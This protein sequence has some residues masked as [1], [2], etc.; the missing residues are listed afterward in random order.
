MPC[1]LFYYGRSNET[2]RVGQDL[3]DRAGDS[4][5]GDASDAR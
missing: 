4:P 2:E 3:L 1:L 5:P